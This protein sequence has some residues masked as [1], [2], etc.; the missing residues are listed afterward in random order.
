MKNLYDKRKTDRF[1]LER[2]RTS[3]VQ[4]AKAKTSLGFLPAKLSPQLNTAAHRRAYTIASNEGTHLASHVGLALPP[5]DRSSGVQLRARAAVV[6]LA[7]ALGACSRGQATV[8]GLRQ[9]LHSEPRFGHA[10]V[11][12]D[13]NVNK[14]RAGGT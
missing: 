5:P 4:D 9:G 3:L 14:L 6:P 13:D 12:R 11:N 1:L 7:A 10:H 2:D 8:F